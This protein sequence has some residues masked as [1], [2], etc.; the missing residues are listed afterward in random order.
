MVD[1]GGEPCILGM[2]SDVTERKRAE[3]A[4]RQSEERFSKGLRM[5]APL[6]IGI[7]RMR[8]AQ[9]SRCQ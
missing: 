2:V 5:P 4:L 7:I 9:I 1:I 8:D 3:E 6:G